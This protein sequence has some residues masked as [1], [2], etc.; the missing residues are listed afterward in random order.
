[1]RRDALG[2]AGGGLSGRAA[3]LPR[4][5]RGP[6]PRAAAGGAFQ[7]D[8]GWPLHHPR[9]AGAAA[10]DPR[11]TGAP[12][13]LPERL[14]APRHPVGG[15]CGRTQPGLRLSLPCLVLQPG[16]PVAWHSPWL[17]LRWRR[18][19]LPEPHRGARSRTFRRRLGAAYAGA[20]AGYGGFL[21]R[22][23][24]G[25]LRQLRHRPA[26]GLRS[27]GHPPAGELEADHRHLPG[28]LPRRQ[29]APG[30][31][32]PPVLAQ[33]GPVRAL[34]PAYPQLLRE[35]QPARDPRP[36]GARLGPAPPRQP[37]V[38]PLAQYPG[39]GGAGP[40]RLLQRVPRRPPGDPGARPYPAGRGAGHGEVAAL[41]REEQRHSLFGAGGGLCHGC[42][43]PGGYS[44]RCLRA[45]LAWALRAGTALV[46]PGAG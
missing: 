22:T 25:R 33:S 35:A 29:G 36:A 37:A 30:H 11:R 19:R 40:Y 10:A 24:I 18:P 2:L 12:A 14:Q 31:H 26:R 43:G 28:E 34:R 4:T 13:R 32:R 38:L 42:A 16:R 21:R 8:R 23:D 15:R 7:R 41:F 1:M 20:G 46:P 44:G 27:A 6:A 5:G 39:A 3:L 45:G 17:R 9:P